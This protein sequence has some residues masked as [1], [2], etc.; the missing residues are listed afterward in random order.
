MG[1]YVSAKVPTVRAGDMVIRPKKSGQGFHFGTG[2]ADGIVAH[3]TPEFGKHLA[4]E[5]RF[6][7]N[8]PF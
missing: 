8:L 5:E 6:A 7:E 4:T 1:V 3:T 2:V